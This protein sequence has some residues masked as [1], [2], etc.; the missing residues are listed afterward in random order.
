MIGPD[1]SEIFSA[2]S[3]ERLRTVL[4][5]ELVNFETILAAANHVVIKLV[6]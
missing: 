6:P 4:V 1:H 5:M 3:L 2:V